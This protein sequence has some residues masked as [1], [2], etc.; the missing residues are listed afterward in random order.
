MASPL[1]ETVGKQLK[2][3]AISG[4]IVVELALKLPLPRGTRRPE[5]KGSVRFV[6]VRLQAQKLGVELEN[7]SGLLRFDRRRRW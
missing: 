1:R 3:L 7:L 4:P 5:V 6:G 2:D